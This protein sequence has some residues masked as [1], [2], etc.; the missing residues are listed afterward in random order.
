[1]TVGKDTRTKI[2]TN[3]TDNAFVLTT[4]VM[5][6]NPE[7]GTQADLDAFLRKR[8]QEG[9]RIQQ[10][11]PRLL[12]GPRYGALVVMHKLTPSRTRM[13]QTAA[14]KVAA[15]RAPAET[16][17]KRRREPVLVG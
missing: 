6:W 14:R 7:G 16:Q 1:M 2:P 8:R 12:E 17:E 3:P 10:C 5:T 4:K 11:V 13:M 9:W 15:P